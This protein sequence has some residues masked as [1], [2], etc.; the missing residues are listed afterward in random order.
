MKD[1]KFDI[2]C[3]LDKV[4]RFAFG[5]GRAGESGEETFAVGYYV[6]SC[7]RSNVVVFK[8]KSEK[9]ETCENGVRFSTE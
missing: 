2:G 3:G 6:K 7:L 9:N 1:L 4:S 5:C 8:V